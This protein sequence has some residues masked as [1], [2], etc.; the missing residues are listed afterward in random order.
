[1]TEKFRK[2]SEFLFWDRN[3]IS[4]KLGQ[5]PKHKEPTQINFMDVGGF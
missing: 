2:V 4:I 5:K 3:K 1:M